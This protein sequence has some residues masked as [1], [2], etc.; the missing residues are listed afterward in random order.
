MPTA[1]LQFAHI[2]RGLLQSEGVGGFCGSSRVSAAA[3]A[4]RRLRRSSDKR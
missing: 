4:H 1:S 2:P 3:S